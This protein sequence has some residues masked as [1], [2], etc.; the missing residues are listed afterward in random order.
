MYKIKMNG[1]EMLLMINAS[2]IVL[3]KRCLCPCDVKSY[4]SY[5]K[6]EDLVSSSHHIRIN[7]EIIYNFSFCLLVGWEICFQS[8]KNQTVF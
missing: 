1:V 4:V 2:T 5:R 7:F 8:Q 3:G 6:S